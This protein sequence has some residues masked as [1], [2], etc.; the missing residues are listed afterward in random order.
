MPSV[1]RQNT[2]PAYPS[3][4]TRRMAASSDAETVL[5]AHSSV[6]DDIVVTRRQLHEELV[7]VTEIQAR[8]IRREFEEQRRQ[9]DAKFEEQR[10]LIEEQRRQTD[11]KFQEQR[12]QTD[13][14]FEELRRHTYL[15]T[16]SLKARIE[17][18][19]TKQGNRG[20][21]RLWSHIR[22][23]AKYDDFVGALVKPENFP[24]RV[25]AFWRL[26]T[27]RGW[28]SMMRLHEFYGTTSWRRW[29]LE[30]LDED[31]DDEVQ[32]L[33]PAHKCLLDAIEYAPDIALQE[34]AQHLGLDYERLTVNVPEDMESLRNRST[35]AKRAVVDD[36]PQELAKRTKQRGSHPS[37]SPEKGELKP[38]S[39]PSSLKTADLI[40]GSPKQPAPSRSKTPS[41]RIGWAPPSEHSR[42]QNSSLSPTSIATSMKGSQ[43]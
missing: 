21:T 23:V 4:N 12:H 26:K 32:E 5:S 30:F 10:L 20:A 42:P 1:P 16:H 17:I 19:D 11:A 43:H 41:T 2:L 39:D 35:R 7:R 9:M 40:G 18:S 33:A 24:D 22:M 15:Q 37:K 28:R 38:E 8:G 3:L 31:S 34:L 25:G 29:G 13:N 14:K 36:E 27:R 6:G